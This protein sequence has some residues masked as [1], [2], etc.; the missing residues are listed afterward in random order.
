MDLLPGNIIEIAGGRRALVWRM[1]PDL[2][3][4]LPCVSDRDP[5]P[6]DVPIH[7]ADFSI[8]AAEAFAWSPA[9]VARTIGSLS[10]EAMER[11]RVAMLLAG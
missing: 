9:K 5:R 4:L 10:S 6:A 8:R 1:S 2:L 7:G 11:V 3:M